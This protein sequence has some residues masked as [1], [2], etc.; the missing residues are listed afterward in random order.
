MA[1][2]KRAAKDCAAATE[3][4]GLNSKGGKRKCRYV[5]TTKLN[6]L[7]RERAN[8]A[9]QNIAFGLQR[10]FG[11]NSG[12]TKSAHSRP[13]FASRLRID[14]NSQRRLRSLSGKQF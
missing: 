2:S 3:N 10:P 12:T 1:W 9:L 4:D 6:S 11:S 13:H 14:G 7:V 5:Q 8:N